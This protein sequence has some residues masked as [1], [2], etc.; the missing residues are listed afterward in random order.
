MFP[1]QFVRSLYIL[2]KLVFS[3][4]GIENVFPVCHLPFDCKY[5]KFCHEG[6]R[7]LYNHI[8]PFFILWILDLVSHLDK[9]SIYK[10]IKN[11]PM[12]FSSTFIVS[13][14]S[15]F[16]SFWTSK[17]LVHLEFIPVKVMDPSY[18]PPDGYSV[19]L[20]TIFKNYLYFPL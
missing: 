5:S 3:E 6:I 4:F 10:I 17:Y 9:I 8:Y 2:G 11:S 18:F 16:F 1:Y 19:V 7:F 14:F 20:N 15:L 12:D 13:F